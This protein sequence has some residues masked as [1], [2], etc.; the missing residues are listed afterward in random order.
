MHP[1]RQKRLHRVQASLQLQHSAEHLVVR[2]DS[3]PL[4]NDYLT[5]REG[6]QQDLHS[7]LFLP[8]CLQ[9]GLL[10]LLQGFAPGGHVVEVVDAPE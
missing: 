5:V 10:L 4:S 1:K 3:L 8:H 9:T 6:L 2:N 7:L